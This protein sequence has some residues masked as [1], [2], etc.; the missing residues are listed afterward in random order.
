MLGVKVKDTSILES[1]YGFRAR[2]SFDCSEDNW[3]SETHSYKK[4]TLT[5]YWYG[6]GGAMIVLPDGII[7]EVK[8][9]WDGKDGFAMFYTMVKNNDIIE[10]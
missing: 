4:G 3:D 10:Y 8:Q 9:S 2:K 6:E 1:K 5:D 7:K